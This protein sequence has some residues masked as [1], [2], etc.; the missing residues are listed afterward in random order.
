MNDTINRRRFLQTGLLG[1]T[2][3]AALPKDALAAVTKPQRDPF[4]GLKLGMAS[5]TLRKF[6]LDQAI[7]MTKQAGLKYINLKDVHL[8]LKS[9]REERQ[10]A[11]KKIV[12]AGL[13]LMGGGVIYMK[14][15]DEEIRAVFDYAKDAGMPAIVCSPEPDALDS[16]EKM[17]KEYDLL[18]AIHN[19]GPGDKKYPSPLDV[20]RLVKDRDPRMGLCMDVGHTVRLGEDPVA[21]IEQAGSR[22]HDFHIK[23]ETKAAANGSPTEV[24]KGVIDIVGVLKALVAAKYP[25]HIGL[26]Y[27]ANETNPLPGV[28]ESVAYMRGVLAAIV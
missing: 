24:G 3:L 22:L 19:H 16:V 14:N 1:T 18:I 12:D 27:E 9:S 17:A 8:S 21:G 25:Y 23:D 6:P 10:D 5:Y 20:L 7:A 4:D 28:I 11:R 2:A 15:N 26:E 13:T